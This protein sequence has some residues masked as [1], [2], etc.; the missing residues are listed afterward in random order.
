ML[1]DDEFRIVLEHHNRPWSGYRKVRKGVKKRLRRHM[2][3]LGCT[4]V[5]AYLEALK[6]RPD[7]AAECELRLL[8]TIS[9]FFRDRLL[10]TF[11]GQR[12]LP[13]IKQSSVLPIRAW[14]A[15]CACGEEPYS[16]A[17][18]WAQRFGA[19]GL[20]ILATDT[21]EICLDRAVQGTYPASSF[22]EVPD[23]L[24]VAFFEPRHGKRRWKIKKSKLP[25]I[26]WRHHH[27]FDASPNDAFHIILLRNSLLTYHQRPE[28]DAAL[29]GIL[30]TL[31]QGGYLI[32]GSHECVPPSF[33]RLRRSDASPWVYR[34]AP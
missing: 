10:W 7:H 20:S 21:Q 8:V 31:R 17:I 13:E 14:S 30:S 15:G 18:A 12:L 3:R 1:S 4:S 11:L 33:P 9:R 25:P 29:S 24:R 5:E 27:L 16:L 32:V 26:E 28:L 23:D 6:T 19:E 2:T 34:L 22:K